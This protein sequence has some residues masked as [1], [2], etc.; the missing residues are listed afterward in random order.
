[1]FQVFLLNTNNLLVIMFSNNYPNLMIISICL[2]TVIWFQVFK[3]SNTNNFLTY[4]TYRW[5]ANLTTP[6]QS[7]TYS[8]C[9]KEVIPCSPKPQNSSPHYQMLFNVNT[10]TPIT[11]SSFTLKN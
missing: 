4:L 9:S 5:D 2:Y 11:Y 6:G 7:V 10:R 8:N 3:Y 1:M